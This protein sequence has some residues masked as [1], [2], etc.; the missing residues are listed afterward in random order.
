MAPST[1]APKTLTEAVRFFSDPDVAQNFFVK[2]R[3]P[4]GV[5]CPTCGSESVAYMAK[6]RRWACS[7][8]HPRRQFTAKVGTIFEDSP[9]PL[10]QWLPA[11]WMIAND[12]NGISSYEL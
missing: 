4:N 10:H 2:L 11:A 8:R 1:N 6:Y 7:S 9:I 12:K 5:T 3:W